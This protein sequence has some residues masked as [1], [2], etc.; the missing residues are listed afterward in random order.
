MPSAD[1][2]LAPELL[3]KFLLEGDPLYLT[4]DPELT[5]VSND[6]VAWTRAEAPELPSTLTCLAFRL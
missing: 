6:S 4:L 1:M 5:S 3:S 2:T